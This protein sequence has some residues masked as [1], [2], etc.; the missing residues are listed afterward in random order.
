M[1]VKESIGRTDH[2]MAGASSHISEE[3]IELSFFRVF[4]NH[5][6]FTLFS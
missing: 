1:Y 3:M 5:D 2:F 6:V 4:P